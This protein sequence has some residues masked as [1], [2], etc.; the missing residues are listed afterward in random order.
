[1]ELNID[2]SVVFLYIKN[3]TIAGCVVA[4]PKTEAYKILSSFEEIDV[5][6]RETYPIKCG[7]SRI[8]VS[9]NN[10]RNGIA[11]A[12]MECV[13][14]NFCYGYILKREEIAMSS[15]SELGKL[16]AR[17]YFQTDEFLIYTS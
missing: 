3:K 1:M 10:R 14:S 2:N 4:E 16:F 9:Q 17:R 5:C 6:S 15:P 13:R 12:L 8:W 11:N 7:I